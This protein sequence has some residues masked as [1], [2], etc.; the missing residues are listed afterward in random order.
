M[1]TSILRNTFVGGEWAPSLYERT[2]QTRYYT[3]CKT[4][5]NFMIKPQGGAIKRGG[6]QF[7]CAV[8]DPTKDVR[9]IPF[10]FSVTQSYMLEFGD[11]YMRVYKDRGRILKSTASPAYNAGTTYNQTDYV[12]YNTVIYYSLVD[13]NL[14][15]QPDIS[16]TEW[17]ALDGF[18]VEIP[19]PYTEDML[20]LLKY[21]QSADVLYIT[22]PSVPPQQLL[23]FSDDQWIIEDIPFGPSI[24]AP[25]G[26][27]MT[28]SSNEYTVTAISEE[29]GSESETATSTTG[30]PDQTLSWT[31][32]T[33][34]LFYKVYEIVNG[35]A[36]Y[37]GL[38]KTNSYYVDSLIEP[39]LNETAPDATNIFDSADNYPGVCTFYQQRLI[40]ARTNNK[41]QT[42]WGSATGAYT[43]FNTSI[44]P[45][46]DESYDFRIDSGQANEI[47]NMTPLT[48]LIFNTSGKEW[49]ANAGTNSSIT[50]NNISLKPQSSYG[51][52]D[53]KPLVIGNNVMFVEN[54]NDLV[55]NLLYSLEIDGY[56]GNDLNIYAKHLV[57]GYNIISWC[58]QR[59][60]YKTIWC[61]RDDG[62]LLG[63]TY[64]LD[65]QI[66]GWHQHSTEGEFLDV[67]S[68]ININGLTDVY[69]VARRLID[70]ALTRYI[71]VLRNPID[72]VLADVRD[73]FYVDSGLSLDVPIAITGATQADPV[74]ITA[75]GHGLINGDRVDISDIVGMTELNGLQ[76]IV[77]NA[78]ASTFSLED[79]NTSNDIDGTGYT[80]YL[81]GGNARKAVTAIA[82]LDHLENEEVAILANGNVVSGL[83]VT[84]GSLTLPNYASRVHIGLAYTADLQPLDFVF[85]GQANDKIKQVKETIIQLQNTRELF[86]G[87]TADK[88]LEVRFRTTEPYSLPIELFNGDKD[89]DLIDDVSR[90]AQVLMRSINPLPITVLS[91]TARVNRGQR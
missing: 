59:E 9:L 83:T 32:V 21:T 44:I 3:A 5:S 70:G 19:T 4:M 15:N 60:P 27:S 64:D 88:L 72:G 73:S 23:R 2:D 58:F 77:A 81:E 43:N 67:E 48:D 6:T 22:H 84:S 53:L 80:A 7:I 41:P 56:S 34:A 75:A 79:I 46:A 85:T 86:I 68:I 35:I 49:Q 40:F 17:Y 13:N 16:P 45:K 30:D 24:A 78:T 14:G 42:F 89:V 55:R 26:L 47:K 51:G 28:G 29:D 31:A 87:P 25:T 54:S 90:N 76:F 36:F 12:T 62:V 57:E 10:T 82:G 65:N 71:E 8:K 91:L 18:I 20:S 66:A 38:A 69:F 39:D 61:V 50:T 74:V 33:G 52:N 11:E 63:L 1:P 37:L